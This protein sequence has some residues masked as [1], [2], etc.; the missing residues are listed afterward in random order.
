MFVLPQNPSI[1][2]GQVPGWSEG[3]LNVGLPLPREGKTSPLMEK[4]LSSLLN[5]DPGLG[6]RL[7]GDDDM[8]RATTPHTE[9]I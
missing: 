2:N 5:Q 6:R 9:L 3:K 7:G 4:M 1:G 8:L